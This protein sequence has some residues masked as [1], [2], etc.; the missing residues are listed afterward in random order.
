MSAVAGRAAAISESA[1]RAAGAL[2][3]AT[4]IGL[5]AFGVAVFLAARGEAGALDLVGAGALALLYGATVWVALRRFLALAGDLAS[6]M[7]GAGAAGAAFG[8]LVYL[9]ATATPLIAQYE[10]LRVARALAGEAAA[11]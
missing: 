3:T 10:A 4:G 7:R 11:P 8:G 2:L 5:L 9:A 1:E 6:A